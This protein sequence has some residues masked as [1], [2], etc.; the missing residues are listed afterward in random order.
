M[1]YTFEKA[2]K[3][4]VKITI[5][6]DGKEWNE[7]QDQAY[8]RTKGRYSLPGF[9]KG[10]VPRNLLEKTYGTGIFYEEAINQCFP[11]YYGEVLDKEPSI[12]AVAN[13][14]VDIKDL[15][16]EKLVLEAIVAVKPEV[17][18]GDYKG[19]NFKKKVYNVKEKDVAEEIES[20][21]K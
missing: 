14:E 13:P 1:K 9:R 8:E 7:A 16:D 10:K 15:S 4:T 21:K 2:E 20:S 17:E 18:L 19:I 5:E 6:L 3:S 11:K 12:V